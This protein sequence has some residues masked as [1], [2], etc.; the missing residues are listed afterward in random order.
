MISIYAATS[1]FAPPPHRYSW[2]HLSPPSSCFEIN[3][4]PW[5]PQVFGTKL[6]PTAQPQVSAHNFNLWWNT[7]EW[8]VLENNHHPWFIDWPILRRIKRRSIGNNISH[9]RKGSFK[10]FHKH[11]NFLLFICELLPF[12]IVFKF[13]L[14]LTIWQ[15]TGYFQIGP[16]HKSGK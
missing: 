10:K 4:F 6:F 1:H 11:N 2:S 14:Y 15:N 9:H 12:A 3:L 13:M 7:R 8:W 16:A 5:Y